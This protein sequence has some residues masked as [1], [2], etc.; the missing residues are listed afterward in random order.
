MG[1][2]TYLWRRGATYYARLDVP[3]DL[4]SII[5][6]TT[7][8]QSLK[9][10]D[11]ATA[12]RLLWPVIERWRREFDDLRARGVLTDDHKAAAVWQ[13]YSQSIERDEGQRGNV[14][15]DSDIETATEKAVERIQHE[16]IDIADTLAMLDAAL[17]VQV[18]QDR[19][20]GGASI[21]A[22]ARRKKL[23]EMRKHLTS[24]NTALINHEVDQFLTENRLYIEARSPDRDV[25]ARQMMRAEIEALQRTIERDEGD[26]TGIPLDPLVRPA[27]GVHR[28]VAEPGQSV[29]EVFEQYVSENPSQVKI[30]TLNQARR[31]IGLFVQ[32][33]GSSYPVAQIDKKNVREWKALL[34]KYPVKAAET[35]VFQGMTIGQVVKH[36]EQ[37]SKPTITA[38][39]VNRHL[40]SL[41]AF[42]RWLVSH[43]YLDQNP[44]EGM[45]LNKEK[46]TKTL[47]FTSDQMNT[48][49]K[50]PLFAGCQSDTHPRFIQKPGNVLI[51]DHRYWVPLIMLFSGARPAEIAQLSVA[52]VRE[53]HGR[54]ILH[55]TDDGDK[56]KS[57]KN[58]NSKRILPVHDKLIKLGLIEYRN[59]M[60][61]AGQKR[62]FPDAERNSRGQMIADFSRMF[63][64][65]LTALGIKNGR[66]YSQYSF[67]HGAADALRRA[68]YLDH[69]F[70]FLMGHGDTSMT[71]RYGVIPQG[72]LEK[73][74][75][76]ISAISYPGLDLDHLLPDRFA[77]KI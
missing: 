55:I 71:G 17:E 69:E 3:S 15:T 25:L 39:T 1:R 51:R 28:A 11:E 68:G 58:E 54:W 64:R 7:R 61:G 46:N 13:H 35:N 6:T 60:L 29:M 40:S 23:S 4:V 22:L 72:M 59:F 9:T 53:E 43:G 63:S 56:D 77:R 50:S 16:E 65:Y 18:L 76:L 67:R 62:L 32:H 70:R 31:D 14:P 34:L 42:C 27:S 48:L 57:V 2:Q 8:K 52:D 12:K 47:T 38:R 45:A 75:E 26:Y 37:I 5:G 10:K 30:D 74:A 66:G 33:V 36:N 19:R 20:K 49:F 44:V 21:D 73:R 24:G 41:G